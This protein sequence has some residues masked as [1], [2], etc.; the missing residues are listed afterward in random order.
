MNDGGDGDYVV[1][2]MGTQCVGGR[3]VELGIGQICGLGLL[4]GP[5]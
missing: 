2:A 1:S 3:N 5:V 4:G